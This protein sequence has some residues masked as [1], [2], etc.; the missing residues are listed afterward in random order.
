[1]CVTNHLSADCP[2]QPAGQRSAFQLDAH[3]DTPPGSLKIGPLLDHVVENRFTQP[4]LPRVNR[5]FVQVGK[6][7]SVFTGRSKKYK[8]KRQK[9]EACKIKKI[10][11]PNRKLQKMKRLEQKI[12]V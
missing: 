4:H 10:K 3:L 8:L 5:S 2:L 6:R 9:D 11:K 1:M 7:G 12:R